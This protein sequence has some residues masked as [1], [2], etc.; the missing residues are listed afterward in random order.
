MGV[1]LN[2]GCGFDRRREFV[3]VDI[4]GDPD[5]RVNLETFPWPWK[6]N[7][8]DEVLLRHVLEHLGAEEEVHFNVLKELYRVCAD[9]AAVNIFV[10]H[11]RHDDFLD[12]PTH[13]RVIT[14]GGLRLLSKANNREWIENGCSN[15]PL[16]LYLDVN[17]EIA[18][19]DYILDPVWEK[20]LDGKGC[21]IKRQAGK[22]YNNVIREVQILM[23]AIKKHDEK[24]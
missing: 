10:P 2:L 18:G 6:D 22:R 20:L 4:C 11:P 13:V 9:G 19:V 21:E 7:S 3:N 12:D 23:K 17:F 14:P 8:V 24:A 5:I 1:K 16:A 15:T